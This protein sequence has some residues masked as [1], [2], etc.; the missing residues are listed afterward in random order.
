MKKSKAMKWVKALRSGKYKQ[1]TGFL[2]VKEDSGDCSYCC[3]GVLG[4]INKLGDSFLVSKDL[5]DSYQVR[6]ACNIATCSGTPFD[7]EGNVDI[8]LRVKNKYVT[9]DSLAYANDNG[10]SFKSIASWIEKNYKFL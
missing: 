7:E 8:L 4:E 3:L 1:A 9:F 5:L 10:A 2:K 6:E